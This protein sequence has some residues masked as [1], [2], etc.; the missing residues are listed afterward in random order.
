MSPETPFPDDATLVAFLDDELA[1]ADA[2]RVRAAL[3]SDR[4]LRQRLALLQAARAEFAWATTRPDASPPRAVA[5]SRGVLP[6]LVAAAALATVVWFGVRAQD[7]PV[8]A[9]ENELLR[10]RLAPV[11][12]AWDL[13]SAIRFELE[14]TALSD[15]AVR[16]VPRKPG[17][18]DDALATRVL[19]ED[20]SGV[21]VVLDAKV[22][23]PDGSVH[24]GPVA[25]TA[26]TFTRKTARTVVELAD[27]KVPYPGIGPKLDVRLDAAGTREDFWWGMQRVGMG[28]TAGISGC[29]P[30][31]P[32]PYRIELTLRSFTG[33]GDSRFLTFT[34]PLTVATGF[35]VRGVVSEW[36]EAVDGMQAR[37]L[38]STATPSATAPLVVAMQ[39]RNGSGRPRI[40]NMTGITGAPIPQPYHFDLVVDETRCRQRADLGVVTPAMTTGLSHPPDT[41]RSYVVHADAWQ[42]ERDGKAVP[43]SQLRGKWR[44]GAIFEFQWTLVDGADPAPWAGKLVVPA[45][46]IDSGDAA[47][48]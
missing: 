42:Q 48:K 27:V 14:G 4:D 38:C 47:A 39:L 11:Q 34:A 46:T 19:A 21:P 37:I 31:A 13:F 45:V 24:Q 28:D 30:E 17:E 26:A 6:A 35:A 23:F 22:T 8:A 7:A 20:P 1:H 2:A 16:I 44:L 15:L 18:S 9:L 32:G 25:R 5:E 33:L 12:P 43:L 41:T 40:Y 29:V 10:V 3:A 36:S